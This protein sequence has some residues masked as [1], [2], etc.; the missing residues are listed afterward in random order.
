VSVTPRKAEA[1]DDGH[2]RE[3]AKQVLEQ[4]GRKLSPFKLLRVIGPGLIS[5]GADNDPAGITT[6]SVVGAQNGFSQNW[7]L[8]LSTP[9]L[10]VVQQMSARIGNV[11]KTDLAASIRQNYG[12]NVAAIAVLL[13]VVANIITIGADLVMMAATIELVTG[14]AFVYFVIPLAGVMG[15]ITIAFDYNTIRKYML[16]LVAVFAAYIVSA[17]LEH[18]HWPTVA[19]QTVIPRI[20]LTS[21]YFLGAVGLLGTTITPFM[22]FWQSSGEVEEKRGVQGIGRS[23]LDISVGMVWSNITA[24]FIMVVTGSVLFS[25]GASINTAADA[26][27]ALEPL[28]GAQAKYLFAVGIIGA[29][30]LAIPVMSAATAYAVAGFFGWRR[31]L[32]RPVSRAPQFYLVLGLALI[33]GVQL[34]V[35]D[36]NPIKALFYSQVLNGLIAPFLILLLLRLSSSRKVMGEFV[37]GRWTNIIAGA[38]IGVMLVADGAL[39]YTVATSG[40]P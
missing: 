26:A 8:I 3:G 28:A 7:L 35:S 37:N 19:S 15:L 9:L 6:Y 13:T 16:W 39:V 24:F 21:T 40:L 32:G 22:F 25:H 38:T 34:A 33:V 31:S 23:N 10:I 12:R 29:G 18:P 36:V 5:G 17:V 4:R 1:T 14:V 11:T 27:Q 2:P 20:N 30:L